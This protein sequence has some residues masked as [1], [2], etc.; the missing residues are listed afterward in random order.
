ML[1]RI[2][3]LVLAGTF[4]IYPNSGKIHS[5]DVEKDTFCIIDDAGDIWQMYGIEDWEVGDN[6]A[7]I[8]DTN[9]TENWIYDDIV[10]SCRYTGRD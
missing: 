2:A 7:M 9:G 1:L 6:C 10:L 5:V 4:S 3:A 8:M